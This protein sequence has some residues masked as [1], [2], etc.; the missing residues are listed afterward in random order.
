MA[1]GNG[2]WQKLALGA[3]GILAT[4]TLAWT[5]SISDD[6]DKV[7]SAIVVLEENQRNIHHEQKIDRDILRRIDKNTGGAGD[8][9]NVRPLREKKH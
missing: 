6:K 3:C 9:P 7:E 8:A 5:A 4:I 1:S 2:V